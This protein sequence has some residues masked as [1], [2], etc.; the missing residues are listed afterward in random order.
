MA[1]SAANIL[2]GACLAYIDDYVAAGSPVGTP[3]EVGFTKGPCTITPSFTDYEVK[4]E[5]ALMTVA[6]S[7]TD[8]KYTVKIPMLEATLANL[9]IAQYNFEHA[10]T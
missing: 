2:I 7:A 4:A 6:K 8:A 1:Q 10:E 3:T 5:Q 9:A